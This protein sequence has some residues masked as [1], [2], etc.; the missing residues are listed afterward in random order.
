MSRT[1]SVHFSPPVGCRINLIDAT[2]GNIVIASTLSI[3]DKTPFKHRTPKGITKG[4]EYFYVKVRNGTKWEF[5]KMMNSLT[6]PNCISEDGRFIFKGGLPNGGTLIGGEHKE[7]L[8]GAA[9]KIE[10]KKVSNVIQTFSN[11]TLLNS[12]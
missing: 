10:S 5:I 12:I 4:K 1:T 3:R 8:R 11:S 7:L 6:L 2:S 9:S